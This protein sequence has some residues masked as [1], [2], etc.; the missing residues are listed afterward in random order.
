MDW[1]Y[2]CWAWVLWPDEE[3]RTVPNL[4]KFV[5]RRL[6]SEAAAAANRDG[7]WRNQMH[8]AAHNGC[9]RRAAQTRALYT[10]LKKL[11]TQNLSDLVETIEARWYNSYSYVN[12]LADMELWGIGADMDACL[13]ARHIITKKLKELEKEAYRLAGKNFSL[14]ATA[15]I[16]DILYT[17]LKLPVPKGCE[18]G[19]CILA[20]TS[21]LWTI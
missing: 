6:H 8:K 21:S 20:L 16:A 12:V 9:C 17:H 19:S 4:E 11:L 5:K 14:N 1:I 10:V 7:R 18:K 15:D 2:V 3:S 13:R